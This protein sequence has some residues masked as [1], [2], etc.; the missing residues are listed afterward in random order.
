M[1]K[2]APIV[3]IF[4]L[5]LVGCGSDEQQ[6]ALPQSFSF[7]AD[8][9]YKD[10]EIT[11]EVYKNDE[12][13]YNIEIVE[14]GILNGLILNIKG[15]ESTISYLGFDIGVAT[16]ILPSDM[17]FMLLTALLDYLSSEDCILFSEDGKSFRM[18]GNL[19]F[20]DFV[21]KTDENKEILEVE[22]KSREFSTKIYHI[23]AIN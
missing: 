11:C 23:N 5:F 2:V 6:L 21:L 12:S 22:I 1:K 8:I 9:A 19:D 18:E 3:I 16:E 10:M 7:M 20:G 17:P 4:L 13:D 14:G 15:G